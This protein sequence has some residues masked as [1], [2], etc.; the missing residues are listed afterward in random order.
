MKKAFQ[1]LSALTTG[2][3]AAGVLLLAGA[4]AFVLITRGAGAI[5]PE[6]LTKETRE[7]GASGGILWQITGTLILVA[8]AAL[9]ALPF[10]TALG[11]TR[12]WLLTPTSRP[13]RTLGF[14]LQLL[15]AVP[16][17]L[18]GILGLILFTGLLDW[19]KSWLAGGILLGI[20]IVPTAA[21]ML[22]HRI[23]SLPRGQ[24]EAAA[25]LGLRRGHIIR[26][27]ILPQSAAALLSGMLLGLARAAGETAPILFVAAVFS[28]ATIPT[29]IREQP[30]LALPY[31][32]FVLAQDS[33]HEASRT[34][35][36]G[37][38]LVLVLL[39]SLPALIAIPLRHKLHNAADH[40]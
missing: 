40:A 38:A 23:E 3:A 37:A 34:N 19:G 39:V 29:G 5:S 12:A 32:I 31:H 13:A 9:I 17:I 20:M 8:T 36:W 16:S 27:V 22:A 6:F 10:A 4:L 2:T 18:L 33:F 21:V 26:A 35:L 1:L 15:N 28:G 11:I 7:A 25:G 30:I 14:I 24:L